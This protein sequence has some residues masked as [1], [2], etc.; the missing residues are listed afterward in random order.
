M[1]KNSLSRVCSHEARWSVAILLVASCSVF[2]SGPNAL[3]VP[4]ELVDQQQTFDNGSNPGDLTSGHKGQTFT[5]SLSSLDWV[6]VKLS[7]GQLD[8]YQVGIRSN[9]LNGPILGA[10]NVVSVPIADGNYVLHMDFSAP[11][12]LTPGNQYAIEVIPVSLND[13]GY[14]VRLS[15]SDLYPSGIYYTSPTS[16]IATDDMWFR[17]GVY[18]P[19]PSTFAMAITLLLALAVAICSRRLG[20]GLTPAAPACCR[21]STRLEPRRLP[22]LL[23]V[24]SRSAWKV[25]RSRLRLRCSFPSSSACL[26]SAEGI[27]RIAAD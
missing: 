14:S 24:I 25:R 18:V 13:T 9:D 7:S 1:R 27:F 22:V 19:E 5:P 16:S 15:L 2:S 23:N 20:C 6:E 8:T 21:R 10:S 11:V 17:E 4:V 12:A 26:V 3:A